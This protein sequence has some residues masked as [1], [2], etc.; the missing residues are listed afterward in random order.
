M[1]DAVGDVAWLQAML[2]VEAAAARAEARVG[3]VPGAAAEAIGACCD[4]RRF[5][6]A[7]L[8]RDAIA[9]VSPVVPLVRA[10]TAEVP[11]EAAGYVH[12]G[13]TTQD[14]IDTAMM[15]ISARALDLLL[16]E[17]EGVAAG[18]AA[19]AAR[20]RD[21]ILPGRTLL[22][23]ALPVTFGLKAAGWLVAT[24]E[25]RDQL[26]DVRRRRLAV[27][28][29]GAAGTLA[30][31]HPHGLA[32]ARELGS[33][34]GLAE[35]L[36]PWHTAR[37]RVAELGCTL[38]V[39]AGVMGKIALDVTLMAQT[40]VGEVRE[41]GGGGSSSIPHKSNPARAVTVNAC[42]RG[43]Q[44]QAGLLLGTMSQEHERAAGAWQAEWAAISEALRLT[45]GAVSRTR[46]LVEGLQIDARR[47]SANAE[48]TH[49]LLL[50]ESVVMTLARR[51]GRPRAQELVRAAAHRAVSSGID[52]RS[53]LLADKDV[54][55]LLRPEE[56]DAALDPG[57]YLGA[58]SELIDRALAAHR[59]RRGR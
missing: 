34:L 18:C 23:H 13:L 59:D 15:L 14:V 6:V 27:Q 46:E 1:L 17:L 41:P 2:D 53:A 22:Q 12:W 8:G 47:M 45:A 55:A 19:L 20:F 16:V 56:V 52:F 9:D 42:V 31:L 57:R 28:C 21:V 10:L 4:A 30:S 39:V 50:S 7:Q 29:G 48:L 49:G 37:G 3:I 11:E 38:S 32:I 33:E 54:V 35:P 51:M 43:V 26:A 25:A 5:D 44:A 40:E 36:L 58:A 24:I